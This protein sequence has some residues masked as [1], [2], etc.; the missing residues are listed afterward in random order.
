MINLLAAALTN[1]GRH[2]ELN[3]D[4]VWAEVYN[5][6]EGDTVGLFIVCDGMGGH[7]GGEV[8]SHWATETI[9]VELKDYFCPKDPRAT[10]KLSEE[11]IDV[12]ATSEPITQKSEITKIENDINK[13]IQ[14]ANKVVYGYAVKKPQEAGDA[15]TTITL[16]FLQGNK[17]VIA[18]VG[19]SRTYLIRDK[20]LKQLTN[21][22]SLVASMV[23][24][25]QLKPE[26]IYS[27]PQR[28]VIY[29]SLG[30]NKQVQIDTFIVHLLPD[31]Y[32]LL[33]SDGLWEMVRDN[34]QI[35]QLVTTSKNPADA[36]E[37]LVGAANRG[38]G[39][40]NIGVVVVNVTGEL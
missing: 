35:V 21:D 13:A 20:Q 14:N 40:D 33:C 28:N 11:A 8:A 38:G 15:G 29:R 17:A 32:L 25:G 10:V 19:D 30:Q 12:P 39:E 34:N 3:E 4:R 26:E 6:S 9:K 1:P 31:D 7:L 24:S 16:A 2:R 36:C 27:H 37:K 23:A 22:H 5:P 18:N